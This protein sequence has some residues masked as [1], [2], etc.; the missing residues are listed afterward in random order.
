MTGNESGTT[1]HH[2]WVALYFDLVFV[3]A[4]GQLTHLI[5][6]EPRW[7]SV[8]VALGLFL[9]LW[10][11]WIGFVVLYNRHGEDR[12]GERLFLL[13]GTVPCAIAAVEAH[14]AL[15]G[16]LIGFGLALA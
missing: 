11:T 3:F 7:K 15:E 16:H 8:A 10:W 2:A 6:D 12:P 5:I 4:V 9:T 1:K 14:D 13:V